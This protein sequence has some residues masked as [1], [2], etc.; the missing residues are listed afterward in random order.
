MTRRSLARVS[1]SEL[2]LA[3][4]NNLFSKI[5]QWTNDFEKG[6]VDQ[7]LWKAELIDLLIWTKLRQRGDTYRLEGCHRIG[8]F[9]NPESRRHVLQ[10]GLIEPWL[11]T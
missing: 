10:M 11:T 4:V 3:V 8:R 5:G 1:G 2:I 7:K 6:L 9:L